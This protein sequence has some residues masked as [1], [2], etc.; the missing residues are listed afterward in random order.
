MDHRRR[1]RLRTYK[2]ARI[3]YHGRRAVIGCVI[4]NLSET[5]ACLGVEGSI[6]IPDSFN[7]VFD[8]G[9]PSRMCRVIWRTDKRLGVEF[10]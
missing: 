9:E 8:T 4:R 1:E 3:A 5:G 7:L 6:G 10:T 2:G